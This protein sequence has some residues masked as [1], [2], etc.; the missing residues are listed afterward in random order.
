MV[1]AIDN[2]IPVEPIEGVGGRAELRYGGAERERAGVAVIEGGDGR[3]AWH[4]DAWRRETDDLRIPGFVRSARQREIDAAVAPGAE[5]PRGRVPNTSSSSRGAALGLSR[6][7][8][9][10]HAGISVG[11]LRSDYGTPAEEDVGI[12]L[13]QDTID[14]SAEAR[15]LAGFVRTLKLR[16]NHTDYRHDEFERQD[17]AV[18]ATFRNRGQEFRVEA[19]HADLGP[20]KGAFGVQHG[21][22]KFSALGD[23]AYLPRT[24]SDST[25]VSSTRSPRAS[26]GS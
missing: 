9:D 12:R 6:T 13:R 1:N 10:G 21:R 16:A 18:G 25:A 7:W 26:A 14:L 11:S 8:A 3:V 4:A 17:G 24:T 2:R 19:L 15:G 20:F 22:S 5:Q 23:E